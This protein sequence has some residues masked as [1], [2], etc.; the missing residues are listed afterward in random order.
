MYTYSRG[1]EKERVKARASK[2]VS[3]R[4]AR[5]GNRANQSRLGYEGVAQ[6]GHAEVSMATT[7]DKSTRNIPEYRQIKPHT[8]M[9][10]RTHTRVRARIP[11]G[12]SAPKKFSLRPIYAAAACSGQSALP[13]G[14]LRPLPF[15][16]HTLFLPPSLPP[17]FSLSSLPLVV[18]G[19]LFAARVFLSFSLYISSF[20]LPLPLSSRDSSC[21]RL[22][23]SPFSAL[24]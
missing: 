22:S 17:S 24:P 20:S 15:M 11:T 13:P 9:C 6:A 14:N 12:N 19:P 3:E 4:D 2:R 10:I 1:R 8:H 21:L 23:L 5:W 7:G 18:L 16:S